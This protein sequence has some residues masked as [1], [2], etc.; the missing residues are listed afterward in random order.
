M[1]IFA[2]H[3]IPE[4]VIFGSD[5]QFQAKSSHNLPLSGSS[6]TLHPSLDIRKLNEWP[7]ERCK[8]E[9]KA[10]MKTLQYAR[11]GHAQIQMLIHA[12]PKSR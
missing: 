5:S 2:R 12:L 9:K 8:R 10:D 1:S 11:T 4:K 6:L 3:E 7:S